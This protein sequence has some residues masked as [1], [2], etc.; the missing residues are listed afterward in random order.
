MS[1]LKERVEWFLK[2]LEFQLQDLAL[3]RDGITCDIYLDTS[4]VRDSVLGMLAFHDPAEGFE[5]DDFERNFNSKRT[6]VHSLAASG[7]LGKI[8]MLPPHQAEFLTLLNI[9]FGDRTESRLETLANSFI[10][11]VKI[12]GS[13]DVDVDVVAINKMNEEELIRFVNQQAGSAEKFFKTV[14]CINGNWQT[15]LWNWREKRILELERKEY[16]YTL[17]IHTKTFKKLKDAFQSKRRD[18]PI[19]NFADAMAV[20]MLIQLFDKFKSGEHKNGEPR[21]IPRFF[22]SSRLFRSALRIADV[23]SELQWEDSTGQRLS[24]LRDEDY[25]VFKSMFRPPPG[26]VQ[27]RASYMAEFTSPESI[28]RVRDRMAELL[29]A[30][31][32][33][34]E[35]LI[36]QIDVAGKPLIEVIADFE[37]LGFLENV[38]L[39]YAAVTEVKGAARRL[40]EAAR[41]LSD[42]DKF[43]QGVGHAVLETRNSLRRNVDE[44][45]AIHSLWTQF[46]SKADALRT[47]LG[48][49][50]DE[51][52]DIFWQLG[53]LRFSFPEAAENRINHVLKALLSGGE[54]ERNARA[55]VIAACQS[56]HS[57]GEGSVED[58]A[59]ASAGLWVTK[60]YPELIKLYE[61]VRVFPHFSLKTIY[62]AALFRVNRSSALGVSLLNELEE[63]H[64]RSKDQLERGD[65]SVGVAYLNFHLAESLGFRAS[66]RESSPAVA[67]DGNEEIRTPINKAISFAKDAYC[68]LKGG[69]LKKRVY[70][71]NQYLYY[72]VEGGGDELIEEMNR[73]AVEL[74]E[75]KRSD[76]ETWQYR[77][78]DTLA[79]YYHRLARSTKSD[80]RWEEFMTA[81]VR[82]SEEA[83]EGAHGDEEV[84][85]N[86]DRIRAERQ[87]VRLSAS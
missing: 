59:L 6:L 4:D 47:L 32:P 5:G 9:Y 33:L 40:I 61:R 2:N 16:D 45:K 31:R 18:K 13:T 73:V 42:S 29:K 39:S 22:L 63:Q 87:V 12:R 1:D 15:R 30:Q 19:S 69:N 56:R 82:R 75:Y 26:A 71:L 44:Y 77:F 54:E 3:E 14:Q 83:W 70:A 84:E 48:G 81:A 49:S 46:K 28:R 36:N 24:V 43:W 80:V 27:P 57:S 38:W 86:M 68:A 20:C 62:A 60:M 65:L 72:M 17:L 10:K 7:W 76:R 11:A 78:D 52:F 41:D 37:R 25:F 74:V 55:S 35:G 85:M 23:E 53:L 34:T 67:E 21:H 79:R 8:H 64:A 66:W 51:T 58:L 50:I